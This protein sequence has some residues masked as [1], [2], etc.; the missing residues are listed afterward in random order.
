MGSGN[1]ESGSV[2]QVLSLTSLSPW[3]EFVNVCKAN[4][5]IMQKSNS[6]W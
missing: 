1:E 3:V 4:W 5:A 2:F 6:K